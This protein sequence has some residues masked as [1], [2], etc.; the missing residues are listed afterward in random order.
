MLGGFF[1][2]LVQAQGHPGGK[3]QGDLF[4]IFIGLHYLCS[5]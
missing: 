4:C 3:N 2:T 1:Y 5:R